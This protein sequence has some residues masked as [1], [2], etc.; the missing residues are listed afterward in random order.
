MS[1]R[2]RQRRRRQ[3]RGGHNR[4]LFLA[5]GVVATTAAIGALA[6]VVW[7]VGLMASAPA[8]DSIQPIRQGATSTVFAANGERPGFTQADPLRT[9][10]GRE[11]TPV[12]TRNATVAIEDRRFYTHQGIDVE[13]VLRAAIKNISSGR[14]VQG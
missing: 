13:G 3:H 1:R 4:P 8:L 11:S 6:V 14:T 2:E 12:N 10:L 7:I 9:P 5:L